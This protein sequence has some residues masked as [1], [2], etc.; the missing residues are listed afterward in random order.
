M[1]NHCVTSRKAHDRLFV[2]FVGNLLRK[3]ATGAMVDVPGPTGS[4]SET[5]V[6][7][8]SL[9]EAEAD[10]FRLNSWIKLNKP[11]SFMISTEELTPKRRKTKSMA[12]IDAE[13]EAERAAGLLDE[14]EDEYDEY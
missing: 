5:E 8:E 3:T 11:R 1:Y 7:M 2:R 10:R 13:I 14:D 6:M 12:E 9:R 4:R